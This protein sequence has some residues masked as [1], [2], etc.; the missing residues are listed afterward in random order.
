MDKNPRSMHVVIYQLS[1]MRSKKN[2][3]LYIICNDFLFS[4]KK[5]F[6][7]FCFL[8]ETYLVVIK[9]KNNF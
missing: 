5:I 4:F 2:L 7:G 6:E 1:K 9:Y 3:T 8:F